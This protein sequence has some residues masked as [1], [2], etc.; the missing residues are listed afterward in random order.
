MTEQ[1]PSQRLPVTRFR[2]LASV[3]AAVLVPLLVVAIVVTGC[4]RKAEPR[5]FKG[6][7]LTDPQPAPDFTAVDHRGQPFRLSDYRGKVVALYFGYTFCP[8]AC[9]T[10]MLDFR[11][12]REALG[13]DADRVQFAMLTVDPERDTPEVLGEYLRVRGHETFVGLTG[14]EEDLAPVWQAY[15]VFVQKAEA[16]RPGIDYW[17]NHTA[18]TYLIDPQGNLRL[19]EPWDA[20]HEMLL[21]DI[22]ILLEEEA[23]R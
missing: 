23:A 5:T 7:V 14:T 4:G 20:G 13:P 9:P 18:A 16:P 8:D 11:R 6:S 12:A 22:Q 1:F 17:M 2:R 10:T 3:L 19:L 21:N 15:G